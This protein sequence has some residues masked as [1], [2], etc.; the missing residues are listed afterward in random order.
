M[1][2]FWQELSPETH[3]LGARVL[4]GPKDLWTRRRRW[5][6]AFRL[7]RIQPDK[8]VRHHAGEEFTHEL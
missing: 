2:R 7:S 8:I 1:Q 4:C 5:T 6:A 3:C